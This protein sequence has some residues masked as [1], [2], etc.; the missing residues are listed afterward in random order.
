MLIELEQYEKITEKICEFIHTKTLETNSS[1]VVFGLSG[2]I[3][4]AVTA[5]LCTRALGKEKCLALILPHEDITPESETNDAIEIINKININYKICNI[6]HCLA[7]HRIYIG[8][9]ILLDSLLV[10]H[11]RHLHQHQNFSFCDIFPS[12][13]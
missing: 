7:F 6:R 12:N 2:G 1:G 13:Y 4:S 9:M 11:I 5:Y 3:D 8:L 10:H